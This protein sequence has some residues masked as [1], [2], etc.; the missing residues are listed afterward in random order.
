MGRPGVGF[1]MTESTLI[2]ASYRWDKWD[3][4]PANQAFVRP[5]GHAFAV[6]LS[7]SFDVMDW[8]PAIR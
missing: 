8:L 5:G 1:R 6:Q 7:Q 3:V 2:K 4:T